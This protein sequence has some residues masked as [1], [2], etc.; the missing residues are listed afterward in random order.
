MPLL[1]HAVELPEDVVEV[2][3]ADVD[4]DRVDELVFVSRHHSGRQ[5]DAV[6]LTVI[7]VDPSGDPAG[8]RTIPLGRVP[9]LWDTE[10]GL[11]GLTA[12]GARDLMRSDTPVVPVSSILSHLGPTSPRAAPL[13]SDIDGDGAPELLVHDGPTGQAAVNELLEQPCVFLLFGWH[14][15]AIF[16][17]FGPFT[18]DD[19]GDEVRN[20][21]Q[22]AN[23]DD[24]LVGGEADA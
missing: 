20:I 22:E 15:K 13:L 14:D 9:M 17:H 6:T 7:D 5:P 24:E 16:G 23:E 10:P 11:W 8:R 2:R 4:S 1:V 18:H 21:K 19:N 3:A 12:D